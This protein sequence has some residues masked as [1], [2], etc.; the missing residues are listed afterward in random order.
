MLAHVT[1]SRDR[2]TGQKTSPAVDPGGLVSS[3]LDLADVELDY[4]TA[5]VAFDRFVDPSAAHSS[6]LTELTQLSNVAIELAGPDASPDARLSALRRLLYDSGPWNGGKPFA[7]DQTDPL[8]QRIENKLLHNYL[9][10][11]LG[12]CVS[13]PILFLIL[14]ERLELNVALV[15]APGHFFVRYFSPSGHTSNIETTSGGHP[16][17]DL[18]F[19]QNFPISD[20]SV[21]TGIYMRSLTKRQA[22]AAMALTIVERLNQDGRF[23]D[24]MEVSDVILSHD[25][26]NVAAMLWKGT[27][28]GRLLDRLR[29]G[30]PTTQWTP[31]RHARAQELMEGNQTWF[32]LAE[33]LGWLP[34]ESEEQC[35]AASSI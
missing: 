15:A 4:V 8:G 11:R 26:M 7:Y 27:A 28:C 10:S 13:M 24:V 9:S 33:R 19:R 16:A 30:C 21:E 6:V 1:I 22:I 32:A 18:W 20:R 17:R 29:A 25:K 2:S 31:D 14:A 35:D 34:F 12:Q 5:K 23:Q 3:I